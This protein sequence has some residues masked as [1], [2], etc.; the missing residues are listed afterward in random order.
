MRRA[1]IYK[2]TNIHNGKSYIGSAVNLYAR[3]HIHF[4]TLKTNKHKNRHLQNAYNKYGKEAFEF[5][6]LLYC[7][8]E[9][10]IFYEQRALDRYDNLYNLKL[11]AGSNL[12]VKYSEESK[13]RMSMV[14]KGLNKTL[15]E[16]HKN[17]LR[18]RKI[19]KETRERMSLANKG[20]KGF[21][22]KHSEET[23]KK[24]SETHKK[25]WETR[26]LEAVYA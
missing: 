1:G 10:L 15:S 8:K 16:E 6:I 21:T 17:I 24:M 14:Q 22:G 19:S 12:G 18:N 13:K 25:R 2:I 4:S 9:N 3:K 23:K 11:I 7:D 26:R 20:G 5:K